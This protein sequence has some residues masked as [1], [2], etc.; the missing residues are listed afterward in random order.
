[1]FQK[2]IIGQVPLV[3]ACN[4]SYL[5]GWNQ[6]DCVLRPTQANYLQ[7]LNL[8]NT[9]SKMDWKCDSSHRLPALLAGSSEF[10]LHSHHKQSHNKK[11][12]KK[13]KKM[14]G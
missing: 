3:H 13:L 4:P 5:V 2:V 9:Q 10:N 1:M 14:E 6:E 8:Q 12:T 7:D 11:D